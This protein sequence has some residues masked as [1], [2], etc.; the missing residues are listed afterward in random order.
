MSETAQDFA[1][2][3]D[4]NANVNEDGAFVPRQC[5]REMVV[6]IDDLAA[7]Y[8]RAVAHLQEWVLVQDGNFP[9]GYVLVC[10]CCEFAKHLGHS[11]DCERAAIIREHQQ[12][13]T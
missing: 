5:Q 6:A 10:P 9:T 7:K 2:W 8:E 4:Y 12:Y 1:R 13:E 3:L 11:T